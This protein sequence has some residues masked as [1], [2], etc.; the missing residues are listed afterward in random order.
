M[1]GFARDRHPPR[2]VRVLI[3]PVTPYGRDEKPTVSFDEGDD[4]GNLHKFIL[5]PRG[6]VQSSGCCNRRSPQGLGHKGI[7]TKADILGDLVSQTEPQGDGHLVRPQC[8]MDSGVQI[9]VQRAR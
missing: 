6:R 9:G 4:V 5:S 3:L 2:L 8:R 7:P 1:A